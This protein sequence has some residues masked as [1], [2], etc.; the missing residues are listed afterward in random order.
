MSTSLSDCSEWKQVFRFGFDPASPP[1]SV[2]NTATTSR[3]SYFFAIYSTTFT[4][5]S[6][7]RILSPPVMPE[8]GTYLISLT[9]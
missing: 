9:C 1:A 8:F 7:S 3:I 5:G 4:T 2:G 6:S